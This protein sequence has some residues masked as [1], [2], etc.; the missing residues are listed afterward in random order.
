VGNWGGLSSCS[1]TG[2]TG[3][4]TADVEKLMCLTKQQIGLSYANTRVKVLSGSAD[5]T[6]DGTFQKGEALIVCAQY[7]VDA[8]AKFVS[9]ALGGAVLKTKTAM[10]IEASYTTQQSGGQEA[11]L[12]GSDWS[13]CTVSGAAP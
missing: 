8:T 12:S 11:A 4:P 13:W 3:D 6:S 7:P 10:R 1:L 9:P 2:V 5:F